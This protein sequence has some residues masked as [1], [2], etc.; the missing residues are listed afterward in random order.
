MTIKVETN[1]R[2]PYLAS[3]LFAAPEIVCDSLA[4]SAS[5]LRPTAVAEMHPDA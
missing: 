4:C 1:A 2:V 5:L 3:V